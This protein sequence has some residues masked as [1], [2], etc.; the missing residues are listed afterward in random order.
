MKFISGLLKI[1]LG[2]WIWV[3][4]T[5]KVYYAYSEY[6]VGGFSDVAWAFSPFNYINIFHIIVFMIP[7]WILM[8]V[9]ESVDKYKNQDDIKFELTASKTVI[10]SNQTS[11]KSFEEKIEN[12]INSPTISVANPPPFISEQDMRP[13]YILFVSSNQFPMGLKMIS[14]KLNADEHLSKH[15]NPASTY[16]IKNEIEIK[17]GNTEL[18]SYDLDCILSNHRYT[19][20]SYCYTITKNELKNLL[21]AKK[22]QF[23]Y[24]D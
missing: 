8:K 9:S 13:G 24:F 14:T 4:F 11:I 6:R 10:E 21:I 15:K 2:A 7:I 19:K 16:R 12:K 20:D 18:M 17:T 3:C 22:I 5:L 23:K 1:I